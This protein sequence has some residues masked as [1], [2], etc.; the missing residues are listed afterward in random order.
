V[1]QR[2]DLLVQVHG[3]FLAFNVDRNSLWGH[4][5]QA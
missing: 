2:D 3:G 4:A 5:V 1:A